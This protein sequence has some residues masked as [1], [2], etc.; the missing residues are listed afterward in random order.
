MSMNKEFSAIKKKNSKL[1]YIDIEMNDNEI[2]NNTNIV[3]KIDFKND[4]S[5]D[6]NVVQNE[7]EDYKP[8]DDFIY[9]SSTNHF[10]MKIF[11]FQFFL[12][13]FLPFTSFL[14]PNREAQFLN[15]K[16]NQ[17]SIMQVLIVPLMFY[18]MF[19]SY[20]MMKYYSDITDN[21]DYN[22]LRGSLWYPALFFALH[23]FIIYNIFISSSVHLKYLFL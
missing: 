11:L 9:S 16:C 12:H 18:G 19:V 15:V 4:L 17:Q 10:Y 3:E 22:V 13:L 1:N 8:I 5:L 21:D 6:I 2:K 7:I 23:R 20:G 14:S